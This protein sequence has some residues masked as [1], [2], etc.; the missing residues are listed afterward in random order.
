MSIDINDM[1]DELIETYFKALDRIKEL[2]EDSNKLEEL[3]KHFKN[4]FKSHEELNK[5]TEQLRH[6]CK[7]QRKYIEKLQKQLLY[8]GISV[9]K[10]EH[11]N[12]L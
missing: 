8:L 10:N 4:L 2:E 3:H 11:T 12:C 1:Y 7:N 9:D 6:I 5:E